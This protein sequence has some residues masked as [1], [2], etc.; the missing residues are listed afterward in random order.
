MGDQKT[1]DIRDQS[2]RDALR[3]ALSDRRLDYWDAIQLVRAT[4]DHGG[5]TSTE[6]AD[7]RRIAAESSTMPAR[8]KELIRFFLLQLARVSGF[9]ALVFHNTL[10]GHD[11]HHPVRIHKGGLPGDDMAQ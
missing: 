3:S 9:Q 2:L 10:R 1:D 8:G 5:I 11:L 6:K 4:F 7:L